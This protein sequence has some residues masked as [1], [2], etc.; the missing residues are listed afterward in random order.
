MQTVRAKFWFYKYYW[1]IAIFLLLF[2]LSIISPIKETDDWKLP[3]SLITA[4]ISFVY[5]IQKQKIE[6]LRLFKELFQEFNDR[7][8]NL[9]DDLNRIYENGINPKSEREDIQKLYDY[10]NLCGEEYLY[11]SKGY[12][13]Q[14]V[15][16]A[17]LNGMRYFYNNNEFKNHWDKELESNSYYRFNKN[18]FS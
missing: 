18:I 8:D 10:F 14:E 5:F 11:Y 16:E 2:I 7:F 15:W 1:I 6:E 9:N 4:A 13:F 17:W 12:I 3:A